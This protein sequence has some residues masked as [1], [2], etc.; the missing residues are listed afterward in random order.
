MNVSADAAYHLNRRRGTVREKAEQPQDEGL[1]D[2]QPGQ[3]RRLIPVD[4]QPHR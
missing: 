2:E 1:F 4:S 3:V